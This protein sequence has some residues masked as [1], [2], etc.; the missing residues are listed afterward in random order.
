MNF[1]IKAVLFDLDGTLLPMDQNHFIKQYFKLLAEYG[2]KSGLDAK[3]LIDGTMAGTLAMLKNDGQ[4]F[5]SQVFWQTYF[6]VTGEKR[7]NTEKLLEP[8]YALDFKKL[9]D[10][11]RE[12]P[13]VKRMIDAAHRN[14]RKVVLAT[15]PVFP[16]EAQL[17]RISW[18]GLS[19][20]DFDHITAYDNSSFCKPNPK[21]YE[22]ICKIIGI[23]P[24]NCIMIGNDD[25]DD[26]K[27]ASEAGME[28]FLID[29]C[30]IS[31][32][33]YVWTGKSGN[34]EDAIALLEKL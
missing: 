1:E 3:R 28:C 29:D 27:G 15:N 9:R 26:M 31:S 7:E 11:T 14:N 12:N 22:E 23:A 18:L 13:A 25:S 32:E 6:A 2:A 8:F 19:E 17:E 16:I 20:N 33:K 4:N 21:Y 24:Q 30:R 5:N 10:F 34:F